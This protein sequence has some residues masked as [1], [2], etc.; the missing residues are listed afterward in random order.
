MF[1]IL[2]SIREP[3]LA[4]RQSHQVRTAYCSFEFSPKYQ[5]KLKQC[6]LLLDA[7]EDFMFCFTENLL[8]KPFALN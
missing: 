1:S 8:V 7:D 4:A 2:R 5:L 6:Q 3:C